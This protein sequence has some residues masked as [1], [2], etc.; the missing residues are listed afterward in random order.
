MT[1]SQYLIFPPAPRSGIGV[2]ALYPP[3]PLLY[4]LQT[5]QSYGINIAMIAQ[6][7]NGLGFSLPAYLSQA[8]GDRI[9]VF[10][11]RPDVTTPSS[12]IDFALTED[13]FEADGKTPKTVLFDITAE[14]LEEKFLPFTDVRLDCWIKVTRLSG[15]PGESPHSQ[16]W[17]KHPAPGEA[18]IDGGKPS[19][20]GSSCQSHR[21]VSSIRT[22]SKRAWKSRSSI[23]S[24]SRSAIR[25]C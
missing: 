9:E 4:K 22:S 12:V 13:D 18:D 25:S 2:L 24:I 23:T 8:L 19:N 7:I 21:K 10:L 14:T 17:F 1:S 15:N 11:D 6:N 5:D 3:Q 16:L 20:Q